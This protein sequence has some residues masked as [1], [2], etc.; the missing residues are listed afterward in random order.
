[1]SRKRKMSAV[2]LDLLHM[3]LDL[4]QSISTAWKS[5]NL[6]VIGTVVDLSSTGGNSAQAPLLHSLPRFLPPNKNLFMYDD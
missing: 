2:C 1:M 4:H 5:A 3:R 6:H